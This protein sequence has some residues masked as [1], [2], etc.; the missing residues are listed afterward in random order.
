MRKILY[1][2]FKSN[3]F[4]NTEDEIQPFIGL[5]K[6]LNLP[7][8]LQEIKTSIRKLNNGRSPEKCDMTAKLI[9]YGPEVLV[10]LIETL[11]NYIFEKHQEI[12]VGDGLIAS[13]PKPKFKG[14]QK[15]LR[16]NL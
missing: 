3:F 11:L 4:T 2:H 13:I 1:K 12:N 9:K 5:A 15:E 6:K 10:T 14:N 16:K 7:I 8:T